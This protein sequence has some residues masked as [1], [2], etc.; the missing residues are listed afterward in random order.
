P[1]PWSSVDEIDHLEI[2]EGNSM[3][4]FHEYSRFFREVRRDFH[5]TGAVLPS[6]VFLAKTIAQ[7]LRGPRPAARILEVG[8]GSGSVTRV[9]AQHLLPGDLFDTVEINPHFARLLEER[10]Q[11]DPDFLPHRDAIR[12]I[13]APVQ[14][15]PGESVYDFII[16][17]LPL[18]NFSTEDIRSIFETLT[19]LVRP[20]GLLSYFEYTFI[21]SLKTPFVGRKERERL[22]SIGQL[23]N[24]YIQ[25]CQVRRDNVLLNLPPATIRHLRLKPE[26]TSR[27]PVP[28]V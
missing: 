27:V 6:G 10:I 14:E 23:L 26:S 16:S 17:G 1:V 20:G 5:H 21:R 24:Q 19:R 7:T 22:S 25:E 8:P 13:Q 9:L 11:T 4:L 12:V 3:H 2:E 15:V 18:N 28:A